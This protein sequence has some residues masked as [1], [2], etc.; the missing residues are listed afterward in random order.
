[1][2]MSIEPSS[3]SDDPARPDAAPLV[4]VL[5]NLRAQLLMVTLGLVTVGLVLVYFPA[6]AS[7]RLQWMTDRAEAA[8]L[9]ALAADVAPGGALGEEEVRALLMGADAV[10]VARVRNGMNELVLYSGPIGEGLVESDL[11]KAGWFTHIR[12]TIET[13]NAPDDR[14][15]RI[16]AHPM[17]APDELIDVIVRE[18]PLH[19]AL[20]EFSRRLLIYASLAAIIVGA[21]LYCALFFLFVRP[22]RRLA[23]A[24]THFREDPA[25]PARMIRPGAAR[26]EIGQAEHELARMQ[27]D[28]RQ[29]L[30]QRERLAALGGAVAKI[31]HDLR[32][33]LA[34]AQ[35]VSDRLAMDS[36]DRVR[37]MGERLVRA[38]DRG[39]RLCEA[40]L[41]FGRAEE[42]APVRQ[43]IAAR[44]LLEEVA[45]DAMLA[46][47][48]VV[49]TND[50]GDELRL[51]ADPDQAHRLFLNLCRNAIQA[52]Q[53]VEGERRLSARATA[54]PLVAD[55]SGEIR[56]EIADSGLGVPPKARER[57]FQ[58]FSGSTRRGGSGLGLSIARELARAHGGDVDLVTTGDAGTV[59]AVRLPAAPPVRP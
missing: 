41:E 50:I 23:G 22:M 44:A 24:M 5:D 34:S 32:N 52:M 14:L 29:A 46:E 6:A 47:G 11:R 3:S 28:V 19:A 12:D 21:V 59:F 38:V 1:M 17:G 54:M 40:T 37:G 43:P 8:H 7:F 35:L 10:A 58:A 4:G 49:W 48:D 53:S 27:A 56:I 33:V 36:D 42:S 30:L 2:P 31:N 45:G 16:R 13:L 57:L 25:D 9:A 18:A 55:G 26:N 15:L 20:R 51:D 39:V